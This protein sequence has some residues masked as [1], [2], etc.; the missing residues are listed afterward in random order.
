MGRP[1]WGKRQQEF[2]K[3]GPV[4]AAAALVQSA[5]KVIFMTHSG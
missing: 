1:S 3:L 2:Q 4:F 5:K